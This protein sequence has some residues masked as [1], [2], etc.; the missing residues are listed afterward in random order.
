MLIFFFKNPKKIK[1]SY[2]QGSSRTSSGLAIV[3]CVLLFCN[4]ELV[5]AMPTR[6]SEAEVMVSCTP[7]LVGI[8]VETPGFTSCIFPDMFHRN[9]QHERSVA[10][11]Q[12]SCQSEGSPK[13]SQETNMTARHHSCHLSRLLD[14]RL[15]CYSPMLDTCSQSKSGSTRCA[16]N[17]DSTVTLHMA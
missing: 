14:G 7:E 11:I 9:A 4:R 6:V 15:L 8:Y 3:L 1:K 17:T 5:I 13:Q 2:R 12:T 16:R 10:V